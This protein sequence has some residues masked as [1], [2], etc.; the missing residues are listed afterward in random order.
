MGKQSKR[1][2]RKKT[3]E[4]TVVY[5]G[6]HIKMPHSQ[7]GWKTHT[8]AIRGLKNMGYDECG[9]APAFSPEELTAAID[10]LL[11][12]K[13]MLV[14]DA[15]NMV[16]KGPNADWSTWPFAGFEL[17]QRALK[18]KNTAFLVLRTK[19]N[20]AGFLGGHIYGLALQLGGMQAAIEHLSGSSTP[21]GVVMIHERT[22]ILP[23]A[24]MQ[25]SP[26]LAA[27]IIVAMM[28]RDESAFSCCVCMESLIRVEGT[29]INDQVALKGF[30]AADCDHAFH[31]VCIMGHIRAGGQ[32]CP[33]CRGPLPV[34][35][36][37][38]DLSNSEQTSQPGLSDELR[39]DGESIGRLD[40]RNP[41]DRPAIMNALADRVRSAMIEDGL[42]PPT[43]AQR[44]Q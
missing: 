29:G 15:T 5:Q 8:Q 12:K 1:D 17:G 37:A 40:P 22:L 24:V 33:M 43:D 6:K 14:F 19:Q 41:Q 16:P 18:V 35:L 38:P 36:A 13:D 20:T 9:M 25:G 2:D 7:P 27:R 23:T 21:C 34:A 31:P 32:G 26:K 42:D 39:W 28:E 10:T 3:N 44:F 4:E 30:V 11:E